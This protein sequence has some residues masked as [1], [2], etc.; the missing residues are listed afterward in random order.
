MDK[1]FATE[2]PGPGDNQKLD[3]KVVFYNLGSSKIGPNT[4]QQSDYIKNVSV[5]KHLFYT[6][7]E[8]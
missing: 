6:H 8:T 1:D 7:Y 4:Q 5:L 2:C 3:P